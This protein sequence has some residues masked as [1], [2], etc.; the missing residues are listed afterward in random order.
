LTAREAAAAKGADQGPVSGKVDQPEQGQRTPG[1]RARLLRSPES[2]FALAGTAR[3][4]AEQNATVRVFTVIPRS[5]P[6]SYDRPYEQA[7]DIRRARYRANLDD[8]MDAL[9]AGVGR[10]VRLLGGEVEKRLVVRADRSHRS[11]R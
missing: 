11:R 8:A 9:P 4:A 7:E 1:D 10:E 6:E 2:R 3:L 5:G